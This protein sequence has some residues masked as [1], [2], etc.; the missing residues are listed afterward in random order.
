MPKPADGDLAS[1]R[2]KLLDNAQQRRPREQGA[3]PPPP[4]EQVGV[5][6]AAHQQL[7]ETVPAVVGDAEPVDKVLVAQAVGLD[8]VGLLAGA[9]AHADVL[10]AVGGQDVRPAAGV[11]AQAHGGQERDVAE[12]QRVLEGGRLGPLRAAAVAPVPDRDLLVHE[13]LPV[14]PRVHGELV[15]LGLVGGPVG[16]WGGGCGSRGG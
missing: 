15:G 4:D 6:T 5:A 7:A 13:R 9:P 10:V 8:D 12:Q 2:D 16:A 3:L 11:A 14:A 1:P